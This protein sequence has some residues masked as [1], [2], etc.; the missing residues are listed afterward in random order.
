M[1]HKSASVTLLDFKVNNSNQNIYFINKSL[2]F[3][4]LQVLPTNINGFIKIYFIIPILLLRKTYIY[5]KILI[6]K[7]VSSIKKT[8][9]VMKSQKVIFQHYP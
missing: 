8:P 6:F 2:T 4:I 7:F 9:I 1:K 5:K 3:E